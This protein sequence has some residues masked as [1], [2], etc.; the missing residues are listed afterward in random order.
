MSTSSA[1]PA[2]EEKPMPEP[3]VQIHQ[4]TQAK[5]QKD[6]SQQNLSLQVSPR[7]CESGPG[8][9]TPPATPVARSRP[10]SLGSCTLELESVRIHR[11]DRPAQHAAPP[12]PPVTRATLS[13]LDVSKIIHNP[14][15]RHDINFDPE[16][17]FRPNLDG[18]RGRKKQ[19]RATAFWATLKDELLEFVTDRQAF[20]LAHGDSDGWSLPAL[21]HAVKEIIQTLV[22]TKDRQFL[23]EGFNV[24]LLIQQFHKGVMDLEKLA[25]WLS[26]VLKSHCAP[27][28][29]E[30]VDAMHDQLRTGNQTGNINLLVTGMRSLLSVLE[31]MKLDVANHQIRCLRPVLIEGTSDFQYSFF[32]KRISSNKL[33]VAPAMVWYRAAEQQYVENADR[34]RRDFGDMGVFF[35]GLTR[36]IFPSSTATRAQVRFEENL[37]KSTF[38]YDEER[39]M[40]LKADMMDLINLD[41]CMRVYESFG[42]NSRSSPT[43]S[44][45]PSASSQ[46]HVL[47]SSSDSGSEFDFNTPPTSSRPSSLVFSS[48][49]SD[50]GS[51]RSP[52]A[53][54]SYVAPG[55]SDCLAKAQDL[56][57]SLVALLQ[58]APSEARPSARWQALV[59][60]MAVE[61][62]RFTEAPSDML[63]TV[64][65]RLMKSIGNTQS[66]LHREA[67][68]RFQADFQA[69]L[70]HRVRDFRGLSA[71][72]LFS[73]A[74]GSRVHQG[75]RVRWE[76][77]AG[78]SMRE[79]V[80]ASGMEDMATRLAHLGILHW[81]VF[82]SLV[83]LS[84]DED[85]SLDDEIS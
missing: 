64:E 14:K 38:Y 25:L 80:E 48:A 46:E 42:R 17:H 4:P 21:L 40:K 49:G 16:L 68:S 35:E 11:K 6:A 29:D 81:R 75:K 57:S 74:T 33:E 2:S 39:I 76:R 78:S 19:E 51:P 43:P 26:Q 65:E 71:V 82:G 85:M 83:Y 61:I 77:R 8:A 23:D 70:A 84:D 62:F 9:A 73:V 12:E 37:F 5:T 34:T 28:R 45:A 10:V 3:D 55:H 1:R 60:S 32:C 15:L 36:L 7:L 18:E 52:A 63:P 31:A 30:W 50:C 56:Y 54:P 67:E 44:L 47:P 58:S 72:S 69:E 22:P 27:M 24:E 53:L 66:P 79:S 13:E 41:I 59:P 20:Y